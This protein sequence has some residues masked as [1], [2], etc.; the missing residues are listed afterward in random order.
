MKVKDDPQHTS[1]KSEPSLPS[2]EIPPLPPNIPLSRIYSDLLKY[3]FNHTERIFVNNTPGGRN[4]W[5]RL[6]NQIAI[7]LATPNGWDTR[8]QLFMRDAVVAAGVIGKDQADELVDY[9]TEGEASVHYAL[10][11]SHSKLWLK[12]GV[13]FAV[14]DAG[15]STVDSTLYECKEHTPKLVLEE[16]R[17]SE[18]IQ[19]G[20]I[21]VDRAARGLLVDK[22][23][24]SRYFD[25][26]IIDIM[27]TEFERK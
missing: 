11:H 3:L 7:V 17:A 20:G 26:E 22:L 9:I 15:G 23:K 6:R 21:F 4:I 24:G 19:A 10:A 12:K 14:T 25:G 18:C 2:I 13:K 8:Q 5:D 27:M 1:V 16:V